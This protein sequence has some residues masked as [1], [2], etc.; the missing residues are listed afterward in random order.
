VSVRVDSGSEGLMSALRSVNAAGVEI[1]DIALRQP[2]LDEVFLALTGP[3][4]DVHKAT[5]AS[6]APV[7]PA[8]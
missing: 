3:P 8:A 2:N 1:D 7:A 4:T 6:A 5:A